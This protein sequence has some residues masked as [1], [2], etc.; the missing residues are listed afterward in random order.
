MTI[1]RS[2]VAIS[3][4]T[5]EQR[6]VSQ[7]TFHF[8]TV[9]GND[10]VASV[11]DIEEALIGF[12]NNIDSLYSANCGATARIKTYRL[13][14]PVPRAPFDDVVFT[15]EPAITAPTLPNEVAACLSFRGANLS[16][17]NRRRNRG[18]IY[19]GPLATA[20]AIDD[21]GDV[22]VA[23]ASRTT[24]TAAA[25]AFLLPVPSPTSGDSI[26]WGVFSK[27]DALGLAVGEPAPAEEPNYTAQQAALGFHEIVQV[28]M[29][30]A[31]DTQRRRGH[32]E[33]VRTIIDA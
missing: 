17:V 29:D 18:R 7:N 6:D 16:G 11:N 1:F 15:F 30:D 4:D 12:Y 2:Q 22:R 25:D 24:F 9:I 33:T 27:S 26:L 31:F 20:V 23:S 5:L 14:D 32:R 28:W 3:N 8:Q 19:L 13:T 21:V 10:D